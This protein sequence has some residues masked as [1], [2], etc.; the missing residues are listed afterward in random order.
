MNAN[1]NAKEIIAAYAEMARQRVDVGWTPY[2]MTFMFRS[3]DG[4]PASIARQME[5]AVEEVYSRFV[6]RVVRYPHKPSAVGRLPVWICCP[7]YPIFKR[8]K[9]S[10]ADV[11][12]NDGRHVHA[13]AL[14]PLVAR[15]PIDLADYFMSDDDGG[16][17]VTPDRPVLRIDVRLTTH[18]LENVVDYAC[19]SAGGG[20]VE[21]GEV[22][23]L[24]RSRTEM[25][26]SKFA[27]RGLLRT[28]AHGSTI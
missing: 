18:N 26:T 11:T 9:Q 23:V 7:D 3:L 12:V 17:Y 4:S 22:F 6:T 10:L 28:A 19:K 5:R 1:V 8:Q 16:L 13:V 24:P 27:P 15:R 2:L 20:R 21:M 14:Q 25:P